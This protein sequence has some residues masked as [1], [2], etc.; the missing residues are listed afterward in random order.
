MWLLEVLAAPVFAEE[1]RI[2]RLQILEYQ[3]SESPHA[4]LT[5]RGICI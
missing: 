1:S 5:V 2:L 3:L 4:I